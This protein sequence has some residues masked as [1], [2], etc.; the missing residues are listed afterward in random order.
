MGVIAREMEI[1]SMWESNHTV[2]EIAAELG[3]GAY[4]VRYRIQDLC[5]GLGPDVGH[6]QAMIAGSRNLR[7]AIEQARAA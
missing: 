5:T 6:E 2:Q 7:V 4:Y 3:V 1:I